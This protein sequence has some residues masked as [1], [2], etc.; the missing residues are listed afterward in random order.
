[1]KRDWE[2]WAVFVT[3]V[4]FLLLL[5]AVAIF[6]PNPTNFQLFVFQ[7]VIA[8]AAA[9]FAVFLPGAINIEVP[10]LRAA[11]VRAVGALAVFVLVFKFSPSMF[12]S[13]PPVPPPPIPNEAPQ[14]ARTFKVCIG[15]GGGDS[16]RSGADASFDCDHYKAMGGGDPQTYKTLGELFC[17]VD[18]NGQKKQLESDVKV[19]SDVGGGQCGWAVF[20][21][22]CHP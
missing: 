11:G 16:C 21:V 7:T 12:V 9:G 3:G 2:R 19:T 6:F 1:M 20:L 14:S 13:Q 22:T 15:N 17:T 10:I 8:V 5:L 4:V 18:Q